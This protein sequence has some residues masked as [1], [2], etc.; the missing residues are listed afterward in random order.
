M[1][2]SILSLKAEVIIKHLLAIEK[3]TINETK[4]AYAG[5]KTYRSNTKLVLKSSK[6]ADQYF[7][8]HYL[9][10]NLIK[11]MPKGDPVHTAQSIG[12]ILNSIDFRE[13]FQSTDDQ[14][15][16][17]LVTFLYENGQ[18]DAADMFSNRLSKQGHGFLIELYRKYNE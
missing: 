2:G 5:N 18:K 13:Y 6:I 15:I 10:D 3:M 7:Q 17:D 9:A 11:L 16:I 8:F 1:F 4:S 12:M 14:Q